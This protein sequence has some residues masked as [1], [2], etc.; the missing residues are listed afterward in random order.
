MSDSLQ[1]H[2]GFLMVAGPSQRAVPVVQLEASAEDALCQME[3]TGRR[4]L[5]VASDSGRLTGILTEAEL[6]QSEIARSGWRK[7]RTVESILSARLKESPSH[8]MQTLKRDVHPGDETHC[9]PILQQGRIVSLLTDDDLFISWKEVEGLLAA[10]AKDQLTDLAS[11]PKFMRR[12][13]E[14]WE[15]SRRRQ[16]PFALLLIDLDDFKQV[17]D[18][19]G[20]LVGDATL[21]EVGAC[22]QAQLRSYDLVGRIGGD[23]FAA[24]CCDC[25]PEDVLAPI[26]RL[27]KSIRALSVPQHLKREAFTLSVGAAVVCGGY[28][29]LTIEAIYEA[30]DEAMYAT[31]RAGR[32]GAFCIVL[33]HDGEHPT[34]ELS[35]LE[36]DAV[37][38]GV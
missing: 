6:L 19:C 37:G 31:K 18:L 15:R 23:E 26:A 24:L 8:W 3:R 29:E 27:R 12:L 25:R 35:R 14:E 13:A 38:L 36:L 33:N 32:D 34:R 28:E 5:L 20:H 7:Q 16:S 11:R 1:V 4:E 21:A 10:S 9:M 30:A 22:L 2:D 17:N